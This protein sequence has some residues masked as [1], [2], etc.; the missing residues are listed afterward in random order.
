MKYELFLWF[1]DGTEYR[2]ED[3]YRTE[4]RAVLA[5]K[6][7]LGF[8]SVYAEVIRTDEDGFSE[9]VFSQP[10]PSINVG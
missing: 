2:S 4:E 10:S 5:A 8:R 9:R 3:L 6:H 7:N 1:V